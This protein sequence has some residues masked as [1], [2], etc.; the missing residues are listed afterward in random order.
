MVH[1]C[2]TGTRCRREHS[3]PITCTAGRTT[4]Q[5]E[6]AAVQLE[7]QLFRCSARARY[8]VLLC[9]MMP[10]CATWFV[11]GACH[12]ASLAQWGCRGV[13]GRRRW[14]LSPQLGWAV[15]ESESALRWQVICLHATGIKVA[16]ETVTLAMLAYLARMA[17]IG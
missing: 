6:E 5:G 14:P 15:I 17:R 13:A 10:F 7:S 16:G 9:H 2:I 4:Q 1:L 3:L 8:G 12:R 11:N